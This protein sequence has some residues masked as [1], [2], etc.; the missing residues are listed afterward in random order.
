VVREAS[1][2]AIETVVGAYDG[3]AANDHADEVIVSR[4]HV[5]AAL[6][7]VDASSS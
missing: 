3:E 1:M 6:E 2:R 4:A 7:R 5:E